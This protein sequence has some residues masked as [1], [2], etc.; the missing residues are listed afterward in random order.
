M[1][2]R[3]VTVAQSP[4]RRI[5]GVRY[6]LACVQQ[7]H[8]RTQSQQSR[9]T[10]QAAEWAGYWAGIATNT[11]LLPLRQLSRDPPA[12][13]LQHASALSNMR[14]RT[15]LHAAGKNNNDANKQRFSDTLTSFCPSSAAVESS[16]I[17]YSTLV[18]R[19][20]KIGGTSLG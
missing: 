10:A 7:Q 13:I 8:G 18:Y 11:A 2:R 15:G 1:M 9:D 5:D 6:S 3:P 20:G 4:R 17:L 19:V 16:S 12:T 14:A